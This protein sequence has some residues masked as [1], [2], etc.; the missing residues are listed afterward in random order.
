[1]S[2]QFISDARINDPAAV[3]KVGQSLVAKVVEVDTDKERCLLSLRL[4]DCYH[5]NTD[6][7]LDLLEN[8]LGEYKFIMD[9]L[10][11]VKGKIVQ[12]HY[13]IHFYRVEQ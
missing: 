12:R 4:S 7:G 13:V 1:M 10:K 3:I 5:G 11:S 9:R 8:W 2:C 6:I